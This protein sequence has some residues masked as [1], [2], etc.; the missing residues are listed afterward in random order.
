[1]IGTDLSPIQPEYVPPN[2]RF[3]IDDADDDWVYSYR[4]DYIHGRYILPFV[5]DIPKM[6]RNVYESL[7]PG[8]YVEIMETLMLMEAI[9]ASLEGTAVD[10]W[11]KMVRGGEFFFFFF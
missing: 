10:R 4:F 11:G 2:L 5:N 7:N 8:G 1:V 6:L 3:E 9:D